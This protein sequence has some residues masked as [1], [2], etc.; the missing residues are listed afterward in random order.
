[1]TLKQ[2]PTTRSAFY[3]LDGSP[4]RI[5]VALDS[6]DRD[7]IALRE[8][9]RLV[10]ATN[11]VAMLVSVVPRPK[12]MLPG[13]IREAEAYLNAVQQGLEEQQGLVAEG[14]VLKGDPATEI[15]RIAHK[16]E[17]DLIVLVTRG[18]HGFMLSSVAESVLA[19]CRAPLILLN[20]ANHLLARE[21][22]T[23][24]QS[25]YVASIVW[26]RKARGKCSE[27]D[28]YEEIEQL[29]REGLDRDVMLA[30]YASLAKKGSAADLL[31]FE[32]QLRTLRKFLPDEVEG[33]D[34]RQPPQQVA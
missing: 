25:T 29:A 11:G 1:V 21:D 10:K 22:D 7:R 17:A 20:E 6:S 34:R 30:T 23:E 15:T 4:V 19:N 2:K 27:Q 13:P 16:L 18:R 31:D 14:I 12:C 8:C 5:L 9:I 24:K 33:L 3:A 28:A 32:F 26:N